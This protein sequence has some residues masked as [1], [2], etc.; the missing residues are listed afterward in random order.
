M[1]KTRRQRRKIYK[2]Q[3]RAQQAQLRSRV[4]ALVKWM[5]ETLY[6]ACIPP[7]IA[8]YHCVETAGKLP[9]LH[10]GVEA[11]VVVPAN[12]IDLHFFLTPSGNPVEGDKSCPSA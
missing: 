10:V 6:S 9:V 3:Q 5:V 4:S 8:T 12:H 11:Q 1:K 2:K 7:K